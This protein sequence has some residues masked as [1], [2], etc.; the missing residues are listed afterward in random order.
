MLLEKGEDCKILKDSDKI[1]FSKD[2]AETLGVES[3]IIL[4][5]YQTQKISNSKDIN[6]VIKSLIIQFLF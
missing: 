5:L 6:V 4:E 3:A 1:S 2:V